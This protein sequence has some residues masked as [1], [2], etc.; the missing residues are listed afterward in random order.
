M[1]HLSAVSYVRLIN[2]RSTDVISAVNISLLTVDNVFPFISL[3]SKQLLKHSNQ[4]T[5]VV[6]GI[7]LGTVLAKHNAIHLSSV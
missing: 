3:Y 2:H 1:F 4:T 5:S 6:F 7:H